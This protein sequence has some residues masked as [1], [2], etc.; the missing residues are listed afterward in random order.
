MKTRIAV[1]AFAALLVSCSTAHK[2]SDRSPNSA[3]ENTDIRKSFNS[4][5]E[6]AD[7]AVSGKEFQIK[8][9]IVDF[10]NGEKGD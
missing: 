8:F 1:F 6:L 5:R 9:I 4:I 3:Q 2:K 10:Q 7:F